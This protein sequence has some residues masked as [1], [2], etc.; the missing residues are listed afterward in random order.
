MKR[1]KSKIFVLSLLGGVALFA[2]QIA[3]FQVMKVDTLEYVSP[4]T[5]KAEELVIRSYRGASNNN[6]YITESREDSGSDRT[7]NISLN[8]FY[9][10]EE[11]NAVR[12]DYDTEIKRIGGSI[13][14]SS[15]RS[16]AHSG[17][18][19]FSI[20]FR[21]PKDP[22]EIDFNKFVDLYPRMLRSSTISEVINCDVHYS[23]KE[24]AQADCDAFVEELKSEFSDCPE[25]ELISAEVTLDSMAPLT[26]V[27][28]YEYC[29]RYKYASACLKEFLHSDKNQK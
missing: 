15:T 13:L 23:T 26:L 7:I 22:S 18:Y 16:L 11:A 25:F 27:G 4:E 3:Y 10:P 2:P 9:T 29:V 14:D 1:K 12:Q 21:Y 5:G 8:G 24:H 28:R 17:Q 19:E 20:V 6:L